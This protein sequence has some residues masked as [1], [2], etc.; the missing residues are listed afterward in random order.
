MKKQKTAGQPL[1]FK[2]PDALK[3]IMDK[4]LDETP[5]KEWTWTGLALAIGGSRQLLS[6]YEKREGYGKIIR[7]AKAHI[8]NS[9]EEDLKESGRAGT[10]FALKNFG[11]KDKQEHEVSTG[12]SGAMFE[13]SF[14]EPEK[15]TKSQK[16]GKPETPVNT[17]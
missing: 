4:Y 11:W 13:I 15:K 14:V 9:Y 5:E 17:A 1:K 2:T 16:N 3:K 10:I 8:E 12:E 6:D 7:T